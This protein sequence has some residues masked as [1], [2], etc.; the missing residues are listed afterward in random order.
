MTTGGC[1]CDI[2]IQDRENLPVADPFRVENDTVL[3]RSNRALV[4]NLPGDVLSITISSRYYIECNRILCS[5]RINVHKK[6]MLKG[7]LVKSMCS[8]L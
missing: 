4:L 6:I 8:D 1:D 5:S 3:C 2:T 7:G